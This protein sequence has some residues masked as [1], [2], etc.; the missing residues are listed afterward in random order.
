[1][2]KLKNLTVSTAMIALLLT[3]GLGYSAKPVEAALGK[4]VCRCAVTKKS[5]PT[6][7]T[8]KV[9][10]F[11]SAKD[12][13]AY[14]DSCPDAPKDLCERSGTG[15]A[16]CNPIT[17]SVISGPFQIPTLGDLMQSLIRLFFFISGILALF[18]LLSGAFDWIRSAGDEE[19]IGK[20]T[21]KITAAILG[22][23]VMVSVLTLVIIIEQVVFAGTVCLGLT[24]PIVL[25]NIRLVTP[26]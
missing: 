26:N 5:E 25:E 7:G 11:N 4:P 23:V 3:V 8:W 13:Q 12:V 24:C 19:A 17:D 1:M 16:D 20:A 6:V 18:Y 21:K 2:N 14:I 9:Q 10:C 15:T 22:L